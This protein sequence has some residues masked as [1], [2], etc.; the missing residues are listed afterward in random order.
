MF[1]YII[2]EINFVNCLCSMLKLCSTGMKFFGNLTIGICS[3]PMFSRVISTIVLGH[4]SVHIGDRYTIYITY[5]CFLNHTCT[6]C[7]LNN[8]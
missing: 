2:W 1:P 8:S 4:Y 7:F 3:R 6:F 5:F